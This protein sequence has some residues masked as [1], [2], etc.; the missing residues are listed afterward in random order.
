MEKTKPTKKTMSPKSDMSEIE[1]LDTAMDESTPK[2]ISFSRLILIVGIILLAAFLYR[3][4]G[5]YIAALVNGTPIPRS[6]VVRELEKQAGKQALDSLITQKL[7]EQE[8]TKR[9]ITVSSDEVDTEIAALQTKFKKEG[10]EL[11]SLLAMQGMTIDDLKNQTRIQKYLEKM[12]SDKVKVTD[13]DVEEFMKA[14]KDGLP[15]DL[16]PDE[17]KK[18]VTEQVKSDKF[19]QEAQKFINDLKSKAKIQYWVKY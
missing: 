11:D 5:V 1:S 18:K 13:K 15:K 2:K 17:L 8:A 14:N 4:R 16:K 19:A 9:K 7:V 12:L 3:E 10:Q 6:Q